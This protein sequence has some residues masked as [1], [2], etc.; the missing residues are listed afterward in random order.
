MVLW[1]TD[2]PTDTPYFESY[3]QR[4]D[5]AREMAR[6]EFASKDQLVTM[7]IAPEEVPFLTDETASLQFGVARELDC[8]ITMHLNCIRHD[9]DP[10][11]IKRGSQKGWLGPD[12]LWVHMAFCTDEEWRMVADSG[13]AVSFTPETELQ[14]GMGI[15][16]LEAVRRHGVNISFGTDIVSNNSGDIFF[17]CGWPCR[18][19]AA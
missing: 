4:A 12:V 3:E 5:M 6:K 11:E 8:R 1:F 14:M 13:G 17:R 15:P 19:G 9:G 2:P 18:S 16:P 10:Q 7:G